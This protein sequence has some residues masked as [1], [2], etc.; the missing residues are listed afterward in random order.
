MNGK[1]HGHLMIES[2]QHSYKEKTPTSKS[3]RESSVFNSSVGG[4]VINM[5]NLE[6]SQLLHI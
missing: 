5:M 6:A 4:L 1:G 3:E 2:A